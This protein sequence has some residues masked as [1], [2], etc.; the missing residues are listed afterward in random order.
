MLRA[1]H[2]NTVDMWSSYSGS[3]LT[4]LTSIKE[5]AGSIPGLTAAAPIQP[6][7]WELP[8]AANGALKKGKK[9]KKEEE[10][11]EKKVC[12]E[13]PG[14]LEVKDLA[15]SLVWLG[16]LL[17]CRFDPWPRNFCM[18]RACPLPTKKNHTHKKKTPAAWKMQ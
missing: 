8:Y 14:S 4:N 13:F 11:E 2:Q 7:A 17:W 16:S 3:A 15:L 5:D 9:K 10:E 18:P 1:P 6:L 12:E